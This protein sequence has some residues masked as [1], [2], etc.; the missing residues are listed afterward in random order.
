MSQL[1]DQPLIAGLEYRQAFISEAEESALM[2]RIE[3]LDVAPF[4]FHGWLGNRKTKSFG[5]RYDFDDASFTPT[6]PIPAWLEPLRDR[7]AALAGVGPAEIHHALVARYDPGAGIGWHKDRDVFER[8]VGVS[9]NTPAT[10]RFRQR[11]ASGFRRATVEVE[12]RSAYLLS[13]PSRWEWEHRIVPGAQLRFSVTFRTLSDQG[14][15]IAAAQR[16]S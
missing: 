2:K 15:R 6:E 7:A 10:L 8:V 11:T 12:P 4:R 14:R 9:L 16:I 13:G 3:A 1:F 5:W